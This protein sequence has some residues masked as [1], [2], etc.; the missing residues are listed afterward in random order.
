MTKNVPCVNSTIEIALEQ[1]QYMISW[2]I[3]NV[4]IAA[5]LHYVCQG[6]KLYT[7]FTSCSVVQVGIFPQRLDQWRS[8]MS[9]RILL[10]MVK[11]HHLLLRS[12]P[13][14]CNF[15]WFN[16]KA[17]TSHHPVIQKE[18]D[19]L[20]AI[21]LLTCGVGFYSNVFLV[22]NLTG[23]LWPILNLGLLSCYMHTCNVMIV[24]SQ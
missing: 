2:Q 8:I 20:L 22:L 4:K 1:I 12:H 10:N 23:G 3:C 17:A 15:K 9:N 11:G 18:V 6:T 5:N 7:S 16:I 24:N 14:F 13:L 21:E 19:E